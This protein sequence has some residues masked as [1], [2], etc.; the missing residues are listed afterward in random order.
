[1]NTHFNELF[2]QQSLKQFTCNV[3]ALHIWPW[4]V[5]DNS[6]QTTYFYVH[7]CNIK[8]TSQKI[9]S[10]IYRDGFNQQ[11]AWRHDTTN[12]RMLCLILSALQLLQIVFLISKK[13]L[14][15]Q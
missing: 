4:Q 15:L 10:N 11:F 9:S 12:D 5:Y 13:C 14:Y 8:T 3:I 7:E 1:M 6:Q 2:Q